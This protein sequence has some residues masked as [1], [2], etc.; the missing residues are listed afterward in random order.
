MTER[1]NEALD[2]ARARWK[3]A[4]PAV[5]RT[6]QAEL[7]RVW[8]GMSADEQRAVSAVLG[9]DDQAEADAQTVDCGPRHV[10]A[11]ALLLSTRAIAH[12]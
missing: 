8:A 12:G 7:D 1:W 10:S 6:I 9:A 5:R 3:G 4:S 11:A 2:W